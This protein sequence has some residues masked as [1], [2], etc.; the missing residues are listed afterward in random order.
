M[1]CPHC[2]HTIPDGSRFCTNCGINLA[3]FAASASDSSAAGTQGS[4]NP[5]NPA[6]QPD[7]ETSPNSQNTQNPQNLYQ[8]P[9]Q[10]QPPQGQYGAPNYGYSDGYSSGYN[11]AYNGAYNGGYNG[12]NP[13]T[14]PP[15]KKKTG[16]VIGILA[17]VVVIL[18]IIAVAVALGKGGKDSSQASSEAS[19][20]VTAESSEEAS[21]SS[22]VSSESSEESS[23]ESSAAESSESSAESSEQSSES[24]AESSSESSSQ[25]STAPAAVPVSTDNGMTL[26]APSGVVLTAGDDTI[27]GQG[28]D[29]Y[30]FARYVSVTP[31][32]I[33]CY[34]VDDMT[35]VCAENPDVAADML[36]FDYFDAVN[37]QSVS[38]GDYTGVV[39]D[40][41][42]AVQG[43]SGTGKLYIVENSVD[44]GIYLMYYLVSDGA[45][46]PE[47]SGAAGD[48]V[49]RSLTQYGT[50]E[51]AYLIFYPESQQ[52]AVL[53]D[54]Q[55]S[56]SYYNVD[57]NQIA[58]G[59]VKYNTDETHLVYLQYDPDNSDI[60]DADSYIS[61]FLTGSGYTASGVVTDVEG[62]RYP[63]RMIQ[64]TTDASM[65]FILMVYRDDT[66][67][68]FYSVYVEGTQEDLSSVD[69]QTTLNDIV[70]SFYISPDSSDSSSSSSSSASSSES[71]Q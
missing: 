23:A 32:K 69:Y 1:I 2:G 61:A 39:F 11:G 35:S 63:F 55:Y 47:A 58:I 44:Y 50:A 40:L 36:G 10:P 9:G 66:T 19:S 30:I 52:F 59:F 54:S 70:Y 25:S 12:G 29:L 7:A 71:S 60:T 42:G 51:P 46:D 34:N 41:S 3:Q 24:S 22:E 13:N 62:G 15:Q 43:Q 64:G 33:I 68:S 4:V 26:S 8:Q 65:N 37:V 49:L 16:L 18:V 27:T 38:F 14:Q 67:G 56:D 17:G 28:T 53:C 57:S 31:N 6:A 20:T 45:A 5:E 21:S 48:Q